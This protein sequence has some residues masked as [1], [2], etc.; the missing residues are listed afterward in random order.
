[1]TIGVGLL[2]AAAWGAAIDPRIALAGLVGTAGYSVIRLARSVQDTE[3]AKIST[4]DHRELDSSAALKDIRFQQTVTHGW[5]EAV[6]LG[7]IA[8]S[9][10]SAER[11]ATRGV[12]LARVPLS[13]PEI[14]TMFHKY[15]KDLTA[16]GDS[17]II[18]ID[19]LDKLD[20]PAAQRFMNELKAIFDEGISGCYYL[21][22]VSEEALAGFHQRGLP[23]RDVF[24]TAFDEMLKVGHL[25]IEGTLDMVGKRI[26]DLPDG[27]A[28]LCH[29]MT[30]GLPRDV[31]RML[32][33]AVATR[34][35]RVS[36]QLAELAQ[37][38]CEQELG[39]RLDGLRTV[40]RDL[41]DW[42]DIAAL[43]EWASGLT[44]DDLSTARPIPEG[45][46]ERAE[47]GKGESEPLRL[48]RLHACSYYH[49]ATVSAFFAKADVDMLE[50]LEVSGGV[51]GAEQLAQARTDMSTDWR[52]SW[53]R[54]T[55]FNRA[56]GLNELEAPEK[57]L[58][59]R[60]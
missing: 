33:K 5:S 25:T 15:V 27:V 13:Y 19:E 14:V 6:K 58:V 57:W 8:P 2:C 4:L 16:N 52:R 45:L 32:R 21:V 3:S 29:A 26:I 54:I 1:M 48:L 59:C 10:L 30:G 37:S 41:P 31:I 36:M 28:A 12:S 42:R 20:P 50:T 39:R 60:K 44:A 17:V 51:N 40:L 55:A 11:T 38:V 43:T 49:L 34:G 46:L 18:G 22:S 7:A 53:E 9:P 23:T 56:W 35:E 47:T 24:D